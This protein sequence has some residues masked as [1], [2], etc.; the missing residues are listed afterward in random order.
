MRVPL[1]FVLLQVWQRALFK[2]RIKVVK[3]RVKA[4]S[5]TRLPQST[6]THEDMDWNPP[7]PGWIEEDAVIPTF[8]RTV[9]KCIKGPA[10]LKSQW[11]FRILAWQQRLY[12][13]CVIYFKKFDCRYLSYI[14]VFIETGQSAS[15]HVCFYWFKKKLTDDLML[16]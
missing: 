1:V 12:F 5:Y 15:M 16:Y 14:N 7:D 13:I 4:S 2:P 10:D 6:H 3:Q 8:W 11:P 9:G